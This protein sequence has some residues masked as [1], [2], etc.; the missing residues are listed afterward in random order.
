MLPVQFFEPELVLMLEFFVK[1]ASVCPTETDL[2][3]RLGW[4]VAKTL[5]R[6]ND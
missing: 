4:A 6:G 5:D 3:M 1:D 2:A